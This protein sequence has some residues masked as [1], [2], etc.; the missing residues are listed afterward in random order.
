MRKN[1]SQ[2]ILHFPFN[3]KIFHPS[4]ISIPR[5]FKQTKIFFTPSLVQ[6]R[7]NNR[8]TSM[9]LIINSLRGLH[10]MLIVMLAINNHFLP[11][12]KQT[13]PFLSL[14]KRKK[15]LTN[16]SLCGQILAKL[17]RNPNKLYRKPLLKFCWTK[18]YYNRKNL[19]FFWTNQKPKN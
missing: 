6:V 2:K 13:L 9:N 17:R 14:G 11:S 12:T 4:Y 1:I 16:D 7:L 18:K 5:I 15:R 19:S 10:N 8:W 3:P